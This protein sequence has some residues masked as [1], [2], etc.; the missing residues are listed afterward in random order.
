MLGDIEPVVDQ[1]IEQVAR[2]PREADA[3]SALGRLLF[4]HGLSK[5]AHNR[6]VRSEQMAKWLKEILAGRIFREPA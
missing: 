2:N 1:A 3:W 4:A 5:Q 6:S